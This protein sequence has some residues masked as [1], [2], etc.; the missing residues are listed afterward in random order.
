MVRKVVSFSLDDDVSLFYF[1]DARVGFVQTMYSINEG[2]SVTILVQL[3]DSIANP[4][5]VQFATV[6]GT[7][8]SSFGGD[9]TAEQR[10][11][12]FEPGGNTIAF[13][14]VQTLSDERAELTE[15]F[16][17]QLSQPSAGLT[18]T[19]DTATIEIADATG[20][21]NQLLLEENNLIIM[22]LL[23]LIRCCC[24]V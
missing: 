9:Y 20:M 18:I 2:D 24:G 5:T 17:A 19:E 11:I 16:T 12:T 13:V 3:F 14:T 23:C 7:A 6:D 10:T 8:D 4:V 1:T 21:P 15:T 22:W